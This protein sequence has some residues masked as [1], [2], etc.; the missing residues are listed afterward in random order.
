VASEAQDRELTGKVA[1]VT[2]SARGIGRA[3][4]LALADRGAD[5]VV[6]DVLEDETRATAAAVVARGR[7]AL[8]IRCNVASREEVE[9]LVQRTVQELGRVDILVNN[10]G[11]T[12]DG[13]LVRMSEEQW[14][15]VL[16]INLKGT[17]LA[18][19]AVA[20]VMMKA[21]S[22]RIVNVASIVGLTGNA[23][24]VNY[25]AS[26]AGVI[27][28]T[29]TLA[30]ELGSRNILVNA[31]A[32]GFIET[33]MTRRLPEAARKAFLDNIPLKRPGLPEDVAKAVCF[34]CSPGAD[35]ISGHCMTVDG[36]LAAY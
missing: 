4:V 20:R 31:V 6:T 5:V 10:A 29:K 19:Q 22:G 3:I 15:R 23:G 8:A 35:Y 9:S 14:D 13:L 24:Q 11:I 25:S 30:K 21:R 16:D 28:L 32:P 7:R 33:E 26:K 17:F 1:I 2:G 36:G 18:S 34:L 12:Q 27:A